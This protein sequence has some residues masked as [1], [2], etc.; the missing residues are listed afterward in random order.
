MGSMKQHIFVSK[1]IPPTPVNY[2]LRRAKLMKKLS[3]WQHAKCSIL[4]SSAGYGKTSLISQFI[5]DHQLKCAWYQITNDD[6]SIFPFFRHFIF[7]I[8]QHYPKFGQGL[9][10]WDETLKFPNTEELIQLSKQLANEL[11]V[12]NKPFIIVLDDFHYVSHVFAINYVMNQLIQFSP[13]HIHIIVATRKMPEWSCL[14]S[15][16]MSNQLI[17]CLEPEFVFS[18]EDVVYLF[19]ELFERRLSE[20][21]CQ[22]VMQ[23]TEGWAMAIM[24]LAY[25]AKYSQEQLF[26]I[27]ESSFDNFFSYL[28]A[29]VFDRIDEQL[30]YQLLQLG[31]HQVISVDVITELYGEEWV[32]EVTPKL[33][34]LAFV[35]QLEGG[36]KYRF[37]A[38]FRQFLLQR[39]QQNFPELFE[40]Y[41]LEASRYYARHNLGVLA[42]SHAA[43][44]Q[45]KEYYTE[46]I[47]EFA[48]QLIEAGQFEFL[49]ER[50]KDFMHEQKPYQLLYYEGECQRYRAQYERAKNA[51]TECFI[52]AQMQQDQLFLMRAQFGLA[53][54]YL[55]TLQPVFAEYHLQQAINF[56]NKV[57][58]SDH[59][60]HYIKSLYTENL[61]N[62][63]RAGEAERWSKENNVQLSIHNIDARLYLRQ[64][65]LELAKEILSKRIEKPFYWEE[66]HRTTDLLL[67]LI[68]VLT[69]ENEQAYSRI[70]G[71]GKEALLDMPYT[72]ALTK[73][74]KGLALI[75]I[76]KS[77]L[78]KAKRCFDE[79]LE[80]F[81]Q[82]HVNRVKAE[83]YMGLI[84]YYHNNVSEAKRH[85]QMGLRETNNV[86]DYWMSA[87]L[88][89]ALTKVLAE[90][91]HYEE[92]LDT[93]AQAL[94]YF[95]KSEDTY[96]RMVCSFWLAYCYA[97]MNQLKE[98]KPFYETYIELCLSQYPF[99]IQKKTLFGP[100]F[101]IEVV[102]LAKMLNQVETLYDSLAMRATPETELT[103]TLFGPV[104]IYRK[105]DPIG[106]KEWKRLK[107][108]E[109]FLYLYL[110]RDQFVSRE[111]LCE[112]IW[113]GD[114]EAMQRDFKVVYNA[115]LKTLEPTRSARVESQF[116]TRRQ[117][118]YKLEDRWIHSDVA[119]FDMYVERGFAEKSGKLSNEWL[120]LA[121]QHVLG[122][123]CSDMLREW[124][125][126]LKEMY[127]ER[128]LKVLERLAQNYVRIQEFEK[129]IRWA[130]KIIA[131]DRGHEEGYRL[132]ILANYYLGNR[133]EAIKQ[134]E[135]CVDALE[136]Q[137]QIQPMESTEA[138]YDLV[139]K[140]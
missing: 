95:E 47:I 136:E 122:E 54:I 89:T 5:S 19:E 86:Q 125:Q 131:L 1:L 34:E 87:L 30:R 37:H 128:I 132:L 46:L 14:L 102:E 134:Y 84:L 63:G 116:V 68:D 96:G 69:G 25:K 2:Y 112:A 78:V 111:Q 92:A 41:H 21:E 45:N 13:K 50:L 88:L 6:D 126:V 10:G 104:V 56:L 27:A 81:N 115:M 137:F 12:I 23:M 60:R 17:E 55:D 76:E 71:G 106:E 53:K 85:A 3:G 28:S 105:N 103:L 75:N 107:A 29:E 20:D 61:I 8:Q 67:V 120:K 64:G 127:T 22:F 114:E 38:L 110:H 98:A 83:C 121:M 36:N 18:E 7:S 35:T 4:H 91:A 124:N 135:R 101:L 51:Y 24:L 108:K 59:E 43:Q 16:R 130:E 123:F 44:L 39:L 57:E 90:N 117:H 26:A 9:V 100:N 74:R 97:K 79:T 113:Q 139:L 31:V 93:A 52:K 109:L 33:S 119:L 49:L 32:K 99:F 42:I 48:A 15:L 82:I 73:L 62:L 58:V 77:N 66:A 40:T 65:K 138:V 80:L 11:Y 94:S 140:M 118:L 70:I 72:L 133:R 129:V